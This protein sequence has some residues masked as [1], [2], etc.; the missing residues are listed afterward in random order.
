MIRGEKPSL[1]LK[2]VV[3]AGERVV[4][5]EYRDFSRARASKI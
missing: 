2:L 1:A 3:D 4:A 5:G